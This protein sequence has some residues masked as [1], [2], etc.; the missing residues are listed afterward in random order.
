MLR[1]RLFEKLGQRTRSPETKN[2]TRHITKT[3]MYTYT[4][5]GI[6]RRYAPDSMPILETMS[7]VKVTVTRK[8]DGTL[9]HH[10]MNSHT[11]FGNPT[12]H[13][14]DIPTTRHRALM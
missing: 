2:G 1:T 10:K 6:N 14:D 4:K 13:S 3:K 8:W 12:S 11:K 9:L 5:F 7:E